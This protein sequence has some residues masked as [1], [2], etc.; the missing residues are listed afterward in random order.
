NVAIPMRVQDAA[1]IR[2]IYAYVQQGTSDG[3]SAFLVKV[4]RDDGATWEPLEYMG[5]AQSIP[6]PHRNTYDWLVKNEGYGKPAARRLPYNDFGIVLAQAVAASGSSQTV[7]TASYGANR[8]GFDVGEFVHI[9]LGGPN[10]EYVRVIAADSNNQTFT[11]V[12]SKDH[13]LGERVRPTIWPTPIL[14][15]GDD[16]AFDIL[17]VA[18]PDAGSDLTVVIQT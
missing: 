7:S 18:S 10:E 5:I 9:D 17:S 16:L 1:S 12:F 2:C 4:S 14:N 15:E 3:Q 6:T 11:A 13:A 8:L